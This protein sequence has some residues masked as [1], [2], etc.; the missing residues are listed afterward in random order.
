MQETLIVSICMLR[1]KISLARTFV[2]TFYE[3][4]IQSFM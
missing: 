3:K 1:K 4:G 2:L